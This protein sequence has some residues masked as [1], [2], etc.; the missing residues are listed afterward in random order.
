[1]LRAEACVR[2]WVWV[3][4]GRKTAVDPLEERC[5]WGRVVSYG[6][7]NQWIWPKSNP[8]IDNLRRGRIRLQGNI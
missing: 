2:V 6:E 3:V 8:C 1:M 5:G 4:D 7:L